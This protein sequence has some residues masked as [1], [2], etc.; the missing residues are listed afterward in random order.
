MQVNKINNFESRNPIFGFNVFEK[1]EEYD[2][3]KPLYLTTNK[4]A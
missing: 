1:Q 2:T 4:N 3:P